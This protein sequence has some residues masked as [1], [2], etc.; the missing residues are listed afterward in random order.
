[1]GGG[2]KFCEPQK[3]L[4]IKKRRRRERIAEYWEMNHLISYFISRKLSLCEK[5]ILHSKGT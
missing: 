4:D 1:V 3:P 2:G 5:I